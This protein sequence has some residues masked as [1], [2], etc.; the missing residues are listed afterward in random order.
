MKKCK[1]C[2]S[3][4]MKVWGIE[5]CTNRDCGKDKK[6]IEACINPQDKKNRKKFGL[7]DVTADFS[8]KGRKK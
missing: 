3:K 1:V 2:G 4:L 5:T 8:G 7:I 6:F